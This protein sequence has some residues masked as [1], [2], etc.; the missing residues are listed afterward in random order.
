MPTA[1]RRLPLAGVRVLDMTRF[2]AGPFCTSLLADQGAEVVK[3][4]RP[5][6]EENRVLGPMVSDEHGGP[7]SSY[8][9]RFAKNKKSICLDL[10]RPEA[11]PVL[12]ALLEHADVLVENFRPGVLERMGLDWPSL[13]ALNE[14]LIYCTIT[15]F[16]YENSP[17][18]ERG[19]FT[20]VVEAMAAAMIYHTPD[21]AP[22]IAGYPVGDIFPAALAA[23]GISMALFRREA[24]GQGARIDMA[25]FD[26][27]LA[28]NERA[29]G[30]SSMLG[31]DLLP[32]IRA[33]IGAA[34]SGVFP[35]K[36]GFVSIAVV[37]EVVW[38]RFCRLLERP[39]WA[40][41][42][43]FGSG[44]ARSEH[45]DELAAFVTQWLSTRTRSEAVELLTGAGVPAGEVA[46]PSEIGASEQAKARDMI[47]QYPAY[48][49][50]VPTVTGNPIRFAGEQRRGAGPAPVAGQHTAEILHE[51]GRLDPADIESLLREGVAIQRDEG[52][53]R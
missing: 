5:E 15:G 36:D 12:R 53:A 14:R 26:G 25:M 23:A 29:V 27:M 34:P 22:T 46:R 32:G 49:G 37:G 50:F 1:D 17:L 21:A 20:P 4:E 28:M 7:V 47:I 40:A 24:D 18:R 52:G 41:D 44:P 38:A 35:A 11:W 13:Q 9:L 16:G 10:K 39:D 45:L 2:V 51:W 33:D 42:E 30:V 48:E 43:R 6:G 3:L 8:F 19:A 31:R